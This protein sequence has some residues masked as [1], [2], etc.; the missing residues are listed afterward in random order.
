MYPYIQT[1]CHNMFFLPAVLAPASYALV[2][3]NLYE[4]FY[5]FIDLF[6]DSMQKGL[7]KRRWIDISCLSIKGSIFISIKLIEI[8]ILFII[9][10]Y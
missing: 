1:Y 8:V 2:M 4:F 6:A 7:I 5:L 10:S 3:L 9:S